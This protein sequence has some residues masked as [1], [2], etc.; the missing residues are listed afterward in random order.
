[1]PAAAIPGFYYD[2]AKKKYF[3]ILPN[4]VAPTGAKYSVEAAKREE[5]EQT[6]GLRSFSIMFEFFP[7]A[8][9]WY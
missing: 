5:E 2:E 9:T 4:H 1:M 6:V 7:V 8:G 3:K